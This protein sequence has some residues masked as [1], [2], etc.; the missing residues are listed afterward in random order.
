MALKVD[1]FTLEGQASTAD[2]YGGSCCQGVQL[3]IQ[4]L[5]KVLAVLALDDL[6]F[7]LL[8]RVPAVILH[9]LTGKAHLLFFFH[10]LLKFLTLTFR[11]CIS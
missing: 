10:L 4:L 7:K 11:G 5:G 9:Y 8:S 6:A 2:G 3:V 1:V